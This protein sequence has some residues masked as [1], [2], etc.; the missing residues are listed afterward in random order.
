MTRPYPPINQHDCSRSPPASA[1]HRNPPS[2]RRNPPPSP[3]GKP[4]CPHHLDRA[5]R[6]LAQRSLQPVARQPPVNGDLV[7]ATRLRANG[8]DPIHARR[9]R[10]RQRQAIPRAGRA[11]WR[12]RVVSHRD[13]RSSGLALSSTPWSPASGH[14]CE[15][16]R[17]WTGGRIH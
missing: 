5:R 11:E 1:I 2:P 13:L 7:H 15:Q 17:W 12:V 10:R 3:T 6:Y 16:W 14:V 8:L 9:R 4:P